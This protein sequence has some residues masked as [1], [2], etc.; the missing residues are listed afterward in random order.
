MRVLLSYQRGSYE[1]RRFSSP[2]K[3]YEQ[4]ESSYILFGGDKSSSP[5]EWQSVWLFN[6][7]TFED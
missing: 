2:V 3:L 4:K 6:I 1:P 5:S 7:D